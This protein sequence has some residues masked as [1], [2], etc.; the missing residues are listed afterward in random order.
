M[1]L[2]QH[3]NS[4]GSGWKLQY[5]V[6]SKV[7]MKH[8]KKAKPE[9]FYSWIQS[10]HEYNEYQSRIK[11]GCFAQKHTSNK[12]KQL[13]LK[14]NT[15]LILEHDHSLSFGAVQ[16]DRGNVASA[17]LFAWLEANFEFLFG[18]WLSQALN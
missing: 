3:K 15:F 18:D 16:L 6:I 17:W 12:I 14:Q 2:N 1:S 7:N 5:S 10:Y 11:S 13:I 9:I 4:K 8:V